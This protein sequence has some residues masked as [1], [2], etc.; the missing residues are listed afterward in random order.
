MLLWASLVLALL[1]AGV[2]ALVLVKHWGEIRLLN[3]ETIRAEQERKARD[4][5]VRD[6][7]Q[8]RLRVLTAP[9]GQAG[10]RAVAAFKQ[11][12]RRMESRLAKAAGASMAGSNDD[13]DARDMKSKLQEARALLRDGK[14]AEAER[15]FLEILKRDKRRI[16]G[17]RG[18]ALLYLQTKQYKQAKELFHFLIRIHGDDDSTYAGLGDIEEAEGDLGQAEHMRK[19][20]LEK[21]PR[22]A[23]RHAELAQF[24]VKYGSPEYAWVHA[25]KACELDPKSPR[26]LELSVETAILVRDRAEAERRYDRLRLVSHDRSKLQSLQE[27]IDALPLGRA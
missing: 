13:G 26:F 11:R 7:F 19:K 14:W 24:Y 3:P 17:Y 25:K 15:A 23:K 6:R 9:L 10:R 22:L 5:M 1:A 21:N 20:A 16:E 4:R 2:I 18:L 12:Y 8:R 27:K